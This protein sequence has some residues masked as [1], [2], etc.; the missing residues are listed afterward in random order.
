MRRRKC[1]DCERRREQSND[2]TRYDRRDPGAQTV[3]R[4]VRLR[5]FQCFVVQVLSEN[6][7]NQRLSKVRFI[8]EK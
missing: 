6:V 3:S 2:V 8:A 1:R 7:N 5:P 4:F